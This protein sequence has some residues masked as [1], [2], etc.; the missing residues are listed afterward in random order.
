M[1]TTRTKT[2][3]AVAVTTMLMTAGVAFAQPGGGSGSESGGTTPGAACAARADGGPT[4]NGPGRAARRGPGAGQGAVASTAGVSAAERAT[5]VFMRQE[6]KLARDVYLT[7]AKTS[8]VPAFS[9]I[10]AA[11][12]RHMDRVGALLRSKGIADPVAGM[13]R[14]EYA[15]PALESL[16]TTLVADGSRSVPAALA[17]GVRVE[18]LDIA[19]I[20]RALAT[21]KR[22]EVRRVLINLRAGSRN[23]LA[24]FTALS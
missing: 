17:V 20:N 19:D 4:G 12:Q 15:D 5:L 1:T 9:R 7:L 23:H 2:V 10:A 22:P 13:T 21:A 14:G 16:Y 24:A 3:A 11:E 18:K 6:E 8:G